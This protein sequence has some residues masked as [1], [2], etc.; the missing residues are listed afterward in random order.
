MII[1]MPTA[2]PIQMLAWAKAFQAPVMSIICEKSPGLFTWCS[3]GSIEVSQL[4]HPAWLD[5]VRATRLGGWLLGF[6]FLASDL[7]CYTAG[8]ALA[9]IVERGLDAGRRDRPVA[10]DASPPPASRS[11]VDV[12]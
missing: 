11:T 2:A 6:G 4:Y 1:G 10:R 12:R 9:V 5:A 7:A 3:T 8:V